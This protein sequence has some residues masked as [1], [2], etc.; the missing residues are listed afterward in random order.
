[1]RVKSFSVIL[2]LVVVVL[3]QGC[4]VNKR[5]KKADKHFDIGEYYVAGDLYKKSYGKIPPKNKSLRAYVAFRQAESYRLINHSRATNIYASAIRNHYP[6]SI[7]YFNY[8]Q[9]LQ[10]EGKYEEAAENYAIYLEYDPTDVAARNGLSAS[11]KADEWIKN[12]TRFK[13]KKAN[14]FN[15]RRASSFS[16]AFVG[17]AGDAMVFTSSRIVDRKKKLKRNSITGMQNNK[18]YS[19]RKNAAGKWESPELLEGEIN[20]ESFDNGVSSFTTDGRTM[21]FTRARKGDNDLGA[22]IMVSSRTGGEWSDP[23]PLKVFEDSTITVAHPTISPD[24]TT[25]YFVSDAPNGYGGKDIWKATLEG[26]D[27]KYIENLGPEINTSGNEMFPM[28]RNDGILFFSSDGHVGLGGL[29]IYK[30]TPSKDEE[31][32]DEVHW[33]VENMGYR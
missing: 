19:V 1:M 30:A 3:L 10:K 28:M 31:D 22:E 32:E 29:D 9:T 15:A 6:D 20:N 24:G 21:Y 16:P 11:E 18:I 27:A 2:F 14:E 12:P 17:N 5:I 7:V 4:G 23:K 8:A 26:G 25:L 13:I 33:F